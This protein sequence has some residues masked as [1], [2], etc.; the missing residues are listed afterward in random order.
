MHSAHETAIISPD[1]TIGAG[2][3]IWQHAQVL[4]GATIGQKCT[5]GHNCTVFGR[6]KLGDYVTLES[7]IDVWDEVTLGDG[8]FLGPSVAL[9]NDL[10]PRA[11]AKKGGVYV[12][13]VI[14]RGASIGANATIVCGV[15]IGQFAV[16]GAGTVVHRDVPAF[17]KM[18]G[19]PARQIGWVCLDN[20]WTKLEFSLSPSVTCTHCGLQYQRH[21]NDVQL[22]SPNP[23]PQ[24]KNS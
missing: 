1:S 9:T 19:V 13:T 20:Q 2:T 17:A 21:G 16:I 11:Y 24:L 5:I 3:R 15:K 23:H 12:P 8:V 6:A 7:N 10:T 4:A 14:E 22:V 18:V